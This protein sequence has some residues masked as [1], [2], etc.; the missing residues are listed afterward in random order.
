MTKNKKIG[1]V[2]ACSRGIGLA[3]VKKLIKNDYI[4][5]MAIRDS[6]KNRKL[7]TQLNKQNENYKHVIYNALEF[8]TY[9]TMINKV[10]NSEGHI[11]LLVNNFGT[12]NI[13]LDT[14]LTEGDPDAYFKIINNNIGSVYYASRYAVDQMIKQKSGGNII[15]ISSIA[16]IT[17]D[18]SRLAYTTSKAAIN[19]I[20]KNI[21]VQYARNNIRC[22]A[23]LPGLVKTDAVANNI[24]DKFLKSFLKH[25]PLGKVVEPDDIAN[26][27]VFLASE[28]SR[29]ITGQ[30][31]PVCGGFGLPTPIYGDVI[32]GQSSLS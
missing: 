22:N 17:P 13:K 32:S 5:Y 4:V 2:T 3:I 15:N 28:K 6:E 29:Y 9:K 14:T 25:V 12:T 21:A 16:G 7:V 23:V 10:V 24:S 18:V 26:A 20:T 11:D 31:L 1:I 8:D 27:V 19:S 30:L